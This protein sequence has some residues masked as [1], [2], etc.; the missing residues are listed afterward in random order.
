MS[1]WLPSGRLTPRSSVWGNPLKYVLN[2]FRANCCGMASNAGFVTLDVVGINASVSRSIYAPRVEPIM[3][4][5]GGLFA[6]T[7]LPKNRT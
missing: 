1:H 3:G 2:V 7:L 5:E 4:V 6:G